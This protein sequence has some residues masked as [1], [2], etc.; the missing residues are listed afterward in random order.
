LLDIEPLTARGFRGPCSW[1]RRDPETGRSI[2][3]GTE[4]R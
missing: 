3:L 1:Y 2:H 4:K